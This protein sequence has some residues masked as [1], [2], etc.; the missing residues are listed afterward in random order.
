MAWELL[1]LC[2]CCWAALLLGFQPVPAA[3]VHGCGLQQAYGMTA[4][5]Y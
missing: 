4:N 1:L 2:R 5:M 3:L